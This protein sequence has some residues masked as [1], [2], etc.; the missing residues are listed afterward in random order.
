MDAAARLTHWTAAPTQWGASAW[1][2]LPWLIVVVALVVVGL[3]VLQR[4][5]KIAEEE[6]LAI[7]RAVAIPSYRQ[8]LPRFQRELDRGRRF[9]R[10]MSILVVRIDADQPR[11][12][13]LVPLREDARQREMR[14]MET[15]GHR[16][17]F[18]HVG[19]VL[20]ECL[21]DMDVTACDA[22]EQRF[23]VALPESTRANVTRLV[24]RLEMLVRRGTG[25]GVRTGVA[26]VGRDGLILADLVRKAAER[27]N[28]ER[29]AAVP[30]GPRAAVAP[31]LAV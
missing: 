26:E 5:R 15:C 13:T 3:V 18:A 2:A 31:R 12:P 22:V 28:E 11:K 8:A 24:E 4:Q 25:L 9:G 6:D 21:R 1:S 7:L 10:P 19:L 27:T 14:A 30:G 20:H 23:V 16:I 17:M 29:T